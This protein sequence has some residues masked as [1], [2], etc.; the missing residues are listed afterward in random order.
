[1]LTIE[2]KA[3]LHRVQGQ[4]EL[5]TG[6]LNHVKEVLKDKMANTKREEKNL[7]DDLH[8]QYNLISVV[9]DELRSAIRGFTNSR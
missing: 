5:L 1:M 3:A 2:Q 7:R 9:E 6:L 4:E 8:S